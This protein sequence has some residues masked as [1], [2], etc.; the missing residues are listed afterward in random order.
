MGRNFDDLQLFTG[1]LI[2]LQQSVYKNIFHVL[3]KYSSAAKIPILDFFAMGRINCGVLGVVPVEL[4][5]HI[6]SWTTGKLHALVHDFSFIN[7]CVY[8]KLRF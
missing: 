7:H 2:L 6:L 8:I 1:M 4:S 3:S 5:A